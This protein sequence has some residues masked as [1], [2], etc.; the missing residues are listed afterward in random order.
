[1]IPRKPLFFVV[2]AII[3]IVVA[4]WPAEAAAQRRVGHRA[5]VR[6][7]VG[8]RYGYPI[9][10][11]YYNPFWWDWYGYQ[12][13]YPYPYPRPYYRYE[14]GSDVRIQVTPRDG[15]VYLDG[16]LVGNVDDFDGMLQRLRVPYGEHEIEV[17]KEGFRPI[18][19]KMLFRPGETYRIRE[20]MQQLPAGEPSEPRPVAAARPE[21]A[22]R[23]GPPGRPD[24]YERQGPPQ[25]Q[26]PPGRPDMPEGARRE[27][28]DETFGTLSI[29][30]QPG[31]ADVLVDG[32]RWDRPSGDNRLT[33]EVVEG[34]HRVEIK[35]DGFK[36]YSTSVQVR[37]GETVTL[38]V[39]LPQQ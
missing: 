4:L 39:S 33:V 15:E 2:P 9:Y 14:P 19:Q 12:Y 35:K 32:E 21:P 29:R 20:T 34:P 18:H 37:R 30:V 36:T 28:N 13:P 26:G 11:Y 22:E 27:R 23:Q 10:P 16:Y 8:V 6:F 1:V 5:T 38:N 31:D 24:P 25:R 17:Y 3:G 7:N